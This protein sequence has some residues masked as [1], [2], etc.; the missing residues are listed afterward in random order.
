MNKD[1]YFGQSPRIA[2]WKINNKFENWLSYK[3]D[4]STFFKSLFVLFYKVFDHK[5]YVG[6][7]PYIREWLAKYQTKWGGN[8]IEKI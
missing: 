2:R 1:K 8:L 7:M 4:N 3:A 6:G 5:Y